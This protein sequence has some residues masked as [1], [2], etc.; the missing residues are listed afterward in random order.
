MS[1]EMTITSNEQGYTLSEM[2][3]VLS[4]FMLI[5]SISVGFL[6]GFSKSMEKQLFMDQMLDDLHYIQHYAMTHNM[7]TIFSID[8][9]NK[10]YYGFT[11]FKEKILVQRSIPNDIKIDKG[12]MNL[13]ITFY[14]EGVPKMSGTWLIRTENSV[15]KFTIYLGSG[16]M[17]I[18]KL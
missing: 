11:D 7:K 12:S 14:Q 6:P 8:T 5:V 16:R 13:E 4:I 9:K 18:E 2:L 15:N 17:K 3:L 10:K 1:N